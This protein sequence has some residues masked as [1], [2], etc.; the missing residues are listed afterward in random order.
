M[1]I[2]WIARE[3]GEG[4][5]AYLALRHLRRLAGPARAIDLLVTGPVSAALAGQLPAGVALHRL[6]VAAES[7]AR[8]LLA[9]REAVAAA[10]HPCLTTDYD[11]VV[12]SSLFPDPVACVAFTSA[13]G[14]RKL[15][16]LL[17]EGL[18]LPVRSEDVQAAM[19]GTIVAAD[20]LLPVS[21]GL[22]DTL[23]RRHP[24]LRSVP[25][26]VIPPPLGEPASD[27]PSPFAAAAAGGLVRVVTVARLSPD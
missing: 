6:E 25:A 7:I 22:L 24:A 9:T 10:G 21:Q 11:A 15:L 12:G 19:Q 16:V 4:G 8:G 18:I 3:F 26:T 5:A 1:S 20:H 27:R 13:R 17:D 14:R 2:L 23:A